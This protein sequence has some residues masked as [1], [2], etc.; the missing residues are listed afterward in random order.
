MWVVAAIPRAWSLATHGLRYLGE[1]RD[2]TW[3]R[4]MVHDIQRREAADPEFPGIPLDSPE[5]REVMTRLWELPAFRHVGQQMSAYMGFRSREDV[6]A[7]AGNDPLALFAWAGEYR[8]A[9]PLIEQATATALERGQ[10][11]LAAYYF[12]LIARVQAGARR[13][14][15][16]AVGLRPSA[17]ALRTRQQATLACASTWQPWVACTSA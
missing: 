4:L 11:A 7:R 16:L 9:L 14:G 13:L 2:T 8:K 6:L 1:R 17:R 10:I 12:T 15:V 5:Q 3:A